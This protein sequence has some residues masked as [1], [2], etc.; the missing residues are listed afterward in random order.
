M[1]RDLA[2]IFFLLSSACYLFTPVDFFFLFTATPMTH[3]IS[4]ASGRI[5]AVADAYTIAT[6]MPDP[7]HIF[8]LYYGLWQCWILHPL[9]EAMD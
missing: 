5:G 3:G 7:S 9:S 8:T 2:F 1:S 6:A 4:Q